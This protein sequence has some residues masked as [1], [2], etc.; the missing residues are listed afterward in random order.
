MGALHCRVGQLGVNGLG[1]EEDINAAPA[2]YRVRGRR[3]RRRER[4][5]LRQRA[6]RAAAAR[7]PHRL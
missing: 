5:A 3:Q 4:A 6:R 7:A 1:G 2:H